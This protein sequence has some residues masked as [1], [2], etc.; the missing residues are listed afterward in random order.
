MTGEK[1]GE[2]Y[3]MCHSLSRNMKSEKKQTSKLTHRHDDSSSIEHEQ[4][5]KKTAEKG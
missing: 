3:H 4:T 2:K 1:M 5:D